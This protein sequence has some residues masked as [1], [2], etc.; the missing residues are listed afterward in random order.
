MD[1][2]SLGI[3]A[4]TIALVSAA[5]K[6]IEILIGKINGKNGKNGFGIEDRKNLRET[7]DW[8]MDTHMFYK[9]FMKDYFKKD[10]DIHQEI[11]DLLRDQ[12]NILEKIAKHELTIKCPLQIDD[13][14]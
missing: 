8:S 11:K 10:A 9:E 1:I 3:I 6:I 12:K 5:M 2:T 14:K 7:R 4:A 13:D